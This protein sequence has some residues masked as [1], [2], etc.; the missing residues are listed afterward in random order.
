MSTRHRRK[1]HVNWSRVLVMNI[2]VS[3]VKTI[4]SQCFVTVIKVAVG[5]TN[6]DLKGEG[7]TF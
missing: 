6:M 2:Q 4:I 3:A 5:C 1:T 7:K